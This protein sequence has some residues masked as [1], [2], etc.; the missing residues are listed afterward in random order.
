VEKLDRLTVRRIVFFADSSLGM[1]RSQLGPFLAAA[2]AHPGF[3]TA[4]VVDTARRR[5]QPLLEGAQRLAITAFNGTD[6][7][8][9]PRYP[10]LRGQA[11]L[12]GVPVVTPSAR[13]VNSV[14]FRDQLARLP[15][16]LVAVSLGCLQIFGPALLGCFEQAVNFHNGLLPDY[17]GLDATGWSLYRGERRSGFSFHRMTTGIDEGAVLADGSVPVDETSRVTDVDREKLAAA[18]RLAPRVLE[19][20]ERCDRGRPQDP[21][22]GRYFSRRDGEAIRRIESPGLLSRGEVLRRLRCFSLL[23]IRLADGWWEATE[24]GESGGP[25]VALADG[26]LAIRRAL[27]LPPPLYRLYRALKS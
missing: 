27:H 7:A 21:G 14:G 6:A 4:C 15:Q 23:R 9:L 5:P 24:L 25:G 13:D 17:R 18:A 1:A 20:I 11:A 8:V 12:F 16:P 22:S 10:S 2:A 19:A 26:A 3:E